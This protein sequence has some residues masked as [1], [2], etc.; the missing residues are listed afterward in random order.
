M[1]CRHMFAV[2]GSV[3]ILLSGSFSWG[4]Q[5]QKKQDL[6]NELVTLQQSTGLS[7]VSVGDD[8]PELI[9]F[10]DR[11]WHPLDNSQKTDRFVSGAVSPDG[12]FLA[13]HLRSPNSRVSSSFLTVARLDGSE[14]REY[15][16]I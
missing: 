11:L 6:R 9:S 15:R 5:K 2:V 4:K 7:F 3:L 8:G 13:G 10:A 12:E 1:R 14:S 16:D